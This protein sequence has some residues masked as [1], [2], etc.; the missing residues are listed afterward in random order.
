MIDPTHIVF[1]FNIRSIKETKKLNSEAK[2]IIYFIWLHPMESSDLPNAMRYLT[3]SNV[4]T[5]L[6]LHH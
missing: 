5:C 1:K 6:V 3:L 4:L 2:K